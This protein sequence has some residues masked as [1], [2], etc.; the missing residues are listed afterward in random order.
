M[1]CLN[2]QELELRICGQAA[3]DLTLLRAHTQY[4]NADEQSAV[5]KNFWAVLN[6]P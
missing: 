5:V 6:G 4:R 1:T 3:V 2:L